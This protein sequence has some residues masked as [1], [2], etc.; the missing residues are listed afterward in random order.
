MATSAKKLLVSIIAF[1]MGTVSSS[2]IGTAECI[3]LVHFVPNM[4]FLQ[5]SQ[6]SEDLIQKFDCGFKLE[7]EK[8][9]TSFSARV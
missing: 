3:S 1:F 6:Q 4:I 5:R 8:R 7:A 2:A 9:Q